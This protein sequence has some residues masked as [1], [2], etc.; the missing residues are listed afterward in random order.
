MDAAL[1]RNLDPL[2]IGA[3]GMTARAL[4]RAGLDVTIVQWRVLLI[5]G[6]S[7]AG[8]TVTE[9]ARRIEA[10]LSPAS[11]LVSRL[12][13][14]GLVATAKDPDDRRTTR[15]TLTVEGRRVRAEV[16]R[17]RRADLRAAI[18]RARIEPGELPALTRL[19][20]AFARHA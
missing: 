3:V 16:L 15:V 18:E 13:R 10:N 7:R 12:E 8:A 17:R 11:R 4:S 1:V 14:R 20:A 2:I 19:A 9:I 5:A 6:E